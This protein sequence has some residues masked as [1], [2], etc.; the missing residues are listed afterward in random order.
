MNNNDLNYSFIEELNN[1]DEHAF[2][3]LF[4]SFFQRLCLF[5]NKIINDNEAAKDIVQNLFI[6]IWQNDSKF[7]N[8]NALHSYL[9]NSVQNRSLNYL[10]D[11]KNNLSTDVVEAEL[12]NIYN[13]YD[14]SDFLLLEMESDIAHEI[15][16]AIDSLPS[17]CKAIFRDSYINML[18][19]KDIAEKYNISA[20]TVKTQRMRAK[21]MLKKKLKNVFA[22][23]I[24]NMI[25]MN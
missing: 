12:L 19:V 2:K 22:I 17:Q 15:N 25:M 14:N 3:I 24:I 10:R 20:N 23:L 4:D 21:E 16:N 1:K 13:K 9:F 11:K 8:E 5:S 18:K 6:R 7:N